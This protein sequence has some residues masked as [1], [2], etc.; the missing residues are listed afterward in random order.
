MAIEIRAAYSSDN[1]PAMDEIAHK[2]AGRVSDFGGMGL[3]FRDLGWV[4]NSELEAEKIKRAL[5]KIG[6]RAEIRN[7]NP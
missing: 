4:A 2:A 6:L 7:T 1:W 3:G 5:D